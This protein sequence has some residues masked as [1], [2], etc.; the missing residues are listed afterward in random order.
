MKKTAIILLLIFTLTLSSCN[1]SNSVKKDDFSDDKASDT[2]SSPKIK[3]FVTFP[4]VK[5]P[6]SYFE[7]EMCEVPKIDETALR[8]IGVIVGKSHSADF[9]F[10]R[11]NTANLPDENYTSVLTVREL[12]TY[13][14]GEHIKTQHLYSYENPSSDGSEKPTETYQYY[15]LTNDSGYVLNETNSVFLLSTF[16][17]D[18]SAENPNAVDPTE[19]LS[20]ECESEVFKTGKKNSLTYISISQNF[21]DSDN[22]GYSQTN[23]EVIYVLKEE[24]IVAWYYSETMTSPTLSGKWKKEIYCIPYNSEIE[25]LDEDILKELNN[26]L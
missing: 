6:T 17:S 8:A 24:N 20:R 16:T 26:K 5:I 13:R 19:I 9:E 1:L 12:N 22:G 21:I 14:D 4:E 10:G 11:I 23:S 18:F 25:T 7:C 2:E 3:D 15:Q